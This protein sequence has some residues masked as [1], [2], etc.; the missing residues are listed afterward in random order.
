M[1]TLPKTHALGAIADLLYQADQ[2]THSQYPCRPSRL[3]RFGSTISANGLSSPQPSAFYSSSSESLNKPHPCP[4]T[5]QVVSNPTPLLYSAFSFTNRSFARDI[6]QSMP[7]YCCFNT[8]TRTSLPPHS[9][10]T[11]TTSPF[12]LTRK[13]TH[14][15]RLS[16]PPVRD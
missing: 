16:K 6:S 2:A 14:F 1:L 3:Q 11:S 10:L 15:T 8:W 7:K 5:P 9:F 12:P 13:L 4:V